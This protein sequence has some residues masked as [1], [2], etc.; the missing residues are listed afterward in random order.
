METITRQ[1]DDPKVAINDIRSLFRE[2]LETNAQ[3]SGPSQEALEHAKLVLHEWLANLAQHADFE[4]RSPDVSVRIRRNEERIHCAVTDNSNGFELKSA[5]DEQ[6]EHS[7]PFPER[8]MGLRIIDACAEDL[9]YERLNDELHRL[10]FS[11]SSNHSPW[12]NNLF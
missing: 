12:L 7:E 9:S 6:H 4:K 11:I 2:W 3:P 10:E 8:M 5:L 1:F